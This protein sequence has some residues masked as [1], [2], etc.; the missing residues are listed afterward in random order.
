MPKRWEDKYAFAIVRNPYDRLISAWKMLTKGTDFIEHQSDISLHDFVDIA[1]D[2]SIPCNKER[3]ARS[4]EVN[5][6]H[7]TVLQSDP[8]L[9]LDAADYIGRF[10]ELQSSIDAIFNTLNKTPVQLPK[11]NKSKHEHYTV[12]LDSDKELKKKVDK[13]VLPDLERF[14]YKY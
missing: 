10:E 3:G 6:R 4:F 2:E 13:F 7:H 14:N 11:M 5:I 1:M 9:C 8:F 12:Y